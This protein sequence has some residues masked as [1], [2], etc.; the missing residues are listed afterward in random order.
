MGLCVSEC[1]FSGQETQRKVVSERTFR[2]KTAV[3]GL[4]ISPQE[5]AVAKVVVAFDQHDA[6]AAGQ[7]ELVG[8][9]GLELVYI[10]ISTWTRSQWKSSNGNGNGGSNSSS[11]SSD[12]DSESNSRNTY[13]RRATGRPGGRRRYATWRPF[14]MEKGGQRAIKIGEQTGGAR[15]TVERG[16]C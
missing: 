5:P 3:V 10:M 14:G 12:S 8:R 13:A 7:A 11:S 4:G 1:F 9:A 15:F 2:K 6:V 16:E